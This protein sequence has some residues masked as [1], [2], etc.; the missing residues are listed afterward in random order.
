MY[1]SICETTTAAYK[2]N[3]LYKVLLLYIHNRVKLYH[4]KYFRLLRFY[5][6]FPHATEFLLACVEKHVMV[7]VFRG[8]SLRQSKTQSEA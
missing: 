7:P 2:T 5:L 1:S 6:H 8:L 4:C 3:A